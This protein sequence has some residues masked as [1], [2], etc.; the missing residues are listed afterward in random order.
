[1][2]RENVSEMADTCDTHF[3]ELFLCLPTYLLE[4]MLEWG[5]FTQTLTNMWNIS[6]RI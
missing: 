2:Y 1:M 6:P 4:S 3:R 5:S